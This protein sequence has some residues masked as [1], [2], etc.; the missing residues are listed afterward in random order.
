M[1]WRH[2]I[3]VTHWRTLGTI[4]SGLVTLIQILMEEDELIRTGE[5]H[6]PLEEAA[7]ILGIKLGLYELDH[8]I[9]MAEVLD[10]KMDFEIERTPLPA[11]PRYEEIEAFVIREVRA[12]VKLQG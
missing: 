7:V 1:N 5:L 3:T 9:E 11:K 2:F 8:V 10:K 12:F 6:F 4:R